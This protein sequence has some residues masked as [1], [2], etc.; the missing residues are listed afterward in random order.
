MIYIKIT[1][2]AGFC[3]HK[4]QILFSELKTEGEFSHLIKYQL[5]RYLLIK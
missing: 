2:K 1:I 4:A 3:D 5:V